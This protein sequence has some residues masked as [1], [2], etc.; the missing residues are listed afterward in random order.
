MWHVTVLGEVRDSQGA[1]SPSPALLALLHSDDWPLQL[2][3]SLAANSWS[4]TSFLRLST[5]TARPPCRAQFCLD[6]CCQS[7]N[8]LL[9]RLQRFPR[10]WP[11]G[12]LP[13]FGTAFSCFRK[14]MISPLCSAPHDK[15]DNDVERSPSEAPNG[16]VNR[17]RDM[18]TLAVYPRLC[19]SSL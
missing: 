7:G 18:V 16:Y 12:P 19:F 8:V 11:C 4:A 15:K 17:S 3:A 2:S 6:R 9:L 5:S 13:P 14:P 10:G 1:P